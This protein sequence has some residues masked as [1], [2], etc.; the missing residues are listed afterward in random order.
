MIHQVIAKSTKGGKYEKSNP[1]P[2]GKK[3]RKHL[4]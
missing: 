1:F 2:K 3:E 4:S